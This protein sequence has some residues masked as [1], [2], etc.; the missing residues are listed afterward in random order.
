MKPAR[1][2]KEDGKEM[3]IISPMAVCIFTKG[4]NVW[5]IDTARKKHCLSMT[6]EEAYYE[7]S[8]AFQE[9]GGAL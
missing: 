5:A 8:R 2:R 4:G 1:L 6:I 3:L 7:I 9:S